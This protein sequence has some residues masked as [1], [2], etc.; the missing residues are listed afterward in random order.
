MRLDV[1]VIGILACLSGV[2][3][4][5]GDDSES[6]GAM[7]AEI[8]TA[9][10]G[11]T[12]TN[13]VVVV[14]P[15]PTYPIYTS[16]SDDQVITFSQGLGITNLTIKAVNLKR[17]EDNSTI[18]MGQD[19]S[20][21]ATTNTDLFTDTATTGRRDETLPPFPFPM[22]NDSVTLLL[23]KDASVRYGTNIGRPLYYEFQWENSTSSG[24][25]YSQLIAVVTAGGSDAAQ[26]AIEATNKDTS[27]ALSE[28]VEGSS[29]DPSAASSTDSPATE[30]STAASRGSSG[31]NGLNTGAIVGIAVGC[32]VAGLIVIAFAAWFFFFR[33][34]GGRGGQT[35]GS[36]YAAGSG[37]RAMVLDKEVTGA[38]ESSPQSAYPEDG[39]RLRDPRGSL[40]RSTDGGSYAPYA[41]RGPSPPAAAAFATNSQTD[42]ASIGQASTTRASTPP[43]Q[44]RY[45]HLIEEGMT[46]DEIRRL[47]EEE[48]HLDAAIE[49][50]AGRITRTPKQL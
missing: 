26:A 48:R 4:A 50:D 17:Y 39:G 34:R 19:F 7:F 10:S 20:T 2:V 33:K 24:S 28:V 44:S 3:A 13:A 22:S 15:L 32:S 12:T 40:V 8:G 37:T 43:Y 25:S 6:H 30:T 9:T 14:E 41:D 1:S 42:L 21:S 31:G 18:A 45:A 27:P 23:K 11:S 38:S 29:T 35:Q 5:E 36:D 46:E 47:E 49:E 16:G